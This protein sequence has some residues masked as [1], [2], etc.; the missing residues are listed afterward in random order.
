MK[1]SIIAT[2][3]GLLLSQCDPP[4]CDPHPIQQPV[5]VAVEEGYRG[6]VDVHPP[7]RLDVYM[8]GDP[9]DDPE[10]FRIRCDNMGGETELIF[11]PYLNRYI[12]ENVDY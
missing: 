10:Y 3:A 1:L 9:D 7:T 8:T 2:A 5:S 4:Q 6:P 12:C 11:N